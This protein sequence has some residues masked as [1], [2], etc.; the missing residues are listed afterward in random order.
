MNYAFNQTTNKVNSLG[1]DSNHGVIRDVI[2]LKP[3]KAC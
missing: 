3:I 2:N 1:T